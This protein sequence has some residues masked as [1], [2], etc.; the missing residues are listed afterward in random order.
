MANFLWLLI[1][2]NP[3][4]ELRTSSILCLNKAAMRMRIRF[5]ALNFAEELFVLCDILDVK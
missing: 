4:N 1:M 2:N 5:H 3:R